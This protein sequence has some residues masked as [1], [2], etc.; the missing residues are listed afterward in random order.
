VSDRYWRE[1]DIRR[2]ADAGKSGDCIEQ[3]AI[4]ES[5]SRSERETRRGGTST[6]SSPRRRSGPLIIGD[7]GLDH[8][9]LRSRQARRGALRI[10]E[11]FGT[12]R[13][14]MR[15]TLLFRAICAASSWPATAI[16][17]PIR[18]A[19]SA[20]ARR[21]T[22]SPA[23]YSPRRRRSGG[24][25]CPIRF[26]ACPGLCRALRRNLTRGRWPRSLGGRWNDR[27]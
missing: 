17:P 5:A 7:E 19:P 13:R 1:A 12:H 26:R 24:C 18:N 15:C 9:P 2:N 10:S 21:R 22:R 11:V 14:S 25:C 16:P 27:F 23:R 8:H 20:R 6:R 3:L 4:H